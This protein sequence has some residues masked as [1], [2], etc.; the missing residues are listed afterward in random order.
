[1]ARSNRDGASLSDRIEALTNAVERA[2][3]RL[4]DDA[5]AFAQH[6][7]TKSSER[8]RHGTSHTLVA[9]LGATGAGKSSLTNALAQ[10]DVATTGVRRPTTSSTMACVW[11][12]ED[13]SPLL[14]WLEIQTRH[15]INSDSINSESPDSQSADSQSAALDGLVLLDVPDHDSVAVEHRLEMERIAEQTDLMLWVT[16]PEKYADAALH[17]YLA[18][19]SKHGPVIVVALNKIDTLSQADRA[20]C[21][22]DLARLVKADGIPDPIVMGVSA[23]TGEGI[24]ELRAALGDA[25]QRQEAA[26]KRLGADVAV[27]ANEMLALTGSDN[28]ARIGSKMRDKLRDDLAGAAG[29]EAVTNA[30]E[31]GHRRD[32]SA[33]TGWPMTRWLGRLR[34]HPL[35]KLHLDKT[36]AGRTSLPAA[37]GAQKARAEAAIRDLADKTSAGMEE[38]WPSLIRKAATPS[39]RELAD[40]LDQAVAGAVRKHQTRRPRWWDVVGGIQALLAVA[41]IV[42]LLWLGVLAVFG[43][44]QIPALPTPR[45]REI[46]IPTG[47]LVLGALLGW[48]LAMVARRLAAVGAK[49]AAARTR[50]RAAEELSEVAD[51]LVLDPIEAELRNRHEL[52]ELLE[53]AGG[54]A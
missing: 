53:L 48:L 1:M 52:V 27:A 23:T 19:L 14:D 40:R 50:K 44:L 8:L 43:Y 47:L 30:V 15:S 4:D 54:R 12:D 7:L 2:H 21:L 34:P 33:A 37:S 13:A 38:P 18:Q 31:L 45:Y 39:S 9:M 5:L 49:R 24:P 28:S 36:S 25:V 41:A 51:E 17:H 11:G 10:S 32:A 29:I 26:V 20:S 35:R 42:G 22:T 46:P 6:V 3:G 16:D